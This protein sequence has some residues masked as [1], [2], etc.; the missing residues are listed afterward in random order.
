M[1]WGW[2]CRAKFVKQLPAMPV[3]RRGPV[4][5]EERAPGPNQYNPPQIFC[6][7]GYSKIKRAPAYTFGH[8]TK[9]SLAKPV[10]TPYAPMFNCQGMSTKGGMSPYKI[11]GSVVTPHI[12]PPCDK[13]KVPAPG[14]YTPC[15]SVRYKRAPVFN[16]RPPARPPYQAWDQWTPPPN[17]YYPPIPKRRPPA[18]SLGYAAHDLKAVEFPGPGEHE[19]N[20][21]YVKSTKP[22]YSFGAPFKRIKP[23]KN[24]PPNTYCEKKF[25]VS[26]RSIPAPSFGIRHSPYLGQQETYLKSSKLDLLTSNVV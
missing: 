17:M 1:P 13:L 15:F 12:E 25:M 14:A 10:T 6:G 7:S 19:P 9:V 8:L 5:G 3:E 18:Y 22:A 2:E 4:A 11:P 20:F 23:P 24:P 26:K 21:N 16:C